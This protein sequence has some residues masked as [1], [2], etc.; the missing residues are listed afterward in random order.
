MSKTFLKQ[1]TRIQFDIQSIKDT[2][3]IV[4]VAS[5]GDALQGTLYI[6]QPDNRISNEVYD[7]THIVAYELYFT[8]L[9]DTEGLCDCGNHPKVEL[10][11]C[12]RKMELEGDDEL[13]DCCEVC[14]SN[15]RDDI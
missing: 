10:H 14:E 9:P 8:V 1:G 4:G 3:T 5:A 2:G 15:C 13:C 12:P 11:D 6:V 7:Y